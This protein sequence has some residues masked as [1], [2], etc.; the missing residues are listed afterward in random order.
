VGDLIPS[1]SNDALSPPADYLIYIC[2]DC[3][4]VCN[5]ILDEKRRERERHG[6]AMDAAADDLT[7]LGPD[8]L[9][10]RQRSLEP[11]FL[12]GTVEG[13]VVPMS[14]AELF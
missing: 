12:P 10:L 3:V 8:L 4:A 2:A 6:S 11:E 13:S 1:P 7:G 5:G 9:C 14:A